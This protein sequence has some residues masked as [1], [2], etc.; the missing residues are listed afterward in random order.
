M[1]GIALALLLGIVGGEGAPSPSDDAVVCL[2]A[3][4]FPYCSGV[5]VGPR[6]VLT[7]GHCIDA[8]G[9]GVHYEVNVGP[10]CHAPLQRL[11]V[12]RRLA[13]PRF[14][15][16]GNPFDLGYLS[17]AADARAAAPFTVGPA[18]VEAGAL[19]GMTVRHVGFGGTDEGSPLSG[20]GIRRSVL[21]AILRVED[22]FIWSGD[23]RSNTCAM[24]SGG[25][26]LLQGEGGEVLVAVVSDGPSCREPGADQRL[27]KGLAWLQARVAEDTVEPPAGGAE[28]GARSTGC[29]AGMGDPALAVLAA[30]WASRRRTRPA[31]RPNS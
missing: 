24:D 7:A 9:P 14:T 3:E 19:P 25:P 10:D 4:G 16:E 28:G 22:D 27:D 6:S 17:L 15:G 26:M 11:G 31:H 1:T 30:Y 29:S 21:H 13:H 23:A 18:P 20:S 8:L 5:L 2:S 12:V